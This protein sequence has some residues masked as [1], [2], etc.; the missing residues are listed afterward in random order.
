MSVNLFL[1]LQSGLVEA[2]LSHHVLFMLEDFLKIGKHELKARLLKM[3][4]LA[5]L[6]VQVLLAPRRL[7]LRSTVQASLG[8]LDN[9][10]YLFK[11]LFICVSVLSAW[12]SGHHV[13]IW[14]LWRQEENIRCPGSGVTDHVEWPC[15]CWDLN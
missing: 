12:M 13:H 11:F 3:V 1:H 6:M 14:F 10:C 5:R 4:I 8:N 15:G 2:I 9:V 7:N